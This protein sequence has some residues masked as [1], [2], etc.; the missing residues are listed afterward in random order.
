[1]S[2]VPPVIESWAAMVFVPPWFLMRLAVRTPVEPARVWS[3]EAK[4]TSSTA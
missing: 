4:S 1:M 2:T 3:P